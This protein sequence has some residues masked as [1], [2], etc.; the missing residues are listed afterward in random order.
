MLMICAFS[1]L[2]TQVLAADLDN[3][4]EEQSP[5]SQ[6]RVMM[7]GEFLDANLLKVSVKAEEMITPVL[8][9]A[10]HLNYEGDKLAFLKYE[11]GNFL[12]RGGDP[13]YLVKNVEEKPELV[14]GET[15]R[16]DDAFP[17]G[18]GRIV[19]LYFQIID[20]EEMKFSFDRGVVSTL[21]T[22]RQDIDKVDWEDLT[23]TKSQEK[24]IAG[25]SGIQASSVTVMDQIF[26]SKNI[27]S[28]L[29]G[30]M[31]MACGL[32]YYLVKRPRE[33]SVNFK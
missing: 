22:V 5:A 31:L 19:D 33:K 17:L 24:A 3:W 13:F 10:F 12:E 15:L 7:E 14:F 16:R 25:G 30:L 21:N 8:G 29:A 28:L 11:P 2:S 18:E 4:D 1:L 23:L 26:D 20:G 6:G 32:F 27:V 9:L